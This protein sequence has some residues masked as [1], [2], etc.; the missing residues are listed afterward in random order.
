MSN[1]SFSNSVFKRL[2][3][4]GRQKVSLH[5]NGLTLPNDKISD[6]AKFYT[7]AEDKLNFARIMISVFD[8]VESIVGKGESADRH[9]L[10]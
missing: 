2:V 5:G 4:Q 10:I 6:W 1:F 9:H 8:K 7:F 3:S